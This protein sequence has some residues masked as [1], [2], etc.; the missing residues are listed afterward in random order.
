MCFLDRTILRQL[1]DSSV[2]IE[3][4]YGF[5]ME[6]YKNWNFILETEDVADLETFFVVNKDTG[7]TIQ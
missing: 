1:A 7:D 2:K 3:D 4:I 5:D 6:L